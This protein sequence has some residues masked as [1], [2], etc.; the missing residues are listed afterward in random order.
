M[1]AY[2]DRANL[3]YLI[4]KFIFFCFFLLNN[5]GTWCSHIFFCKEIIINDLAFKIFAKFK[6]R[7][8]TVFSFLC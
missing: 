7:Y 1:N 5:H 6:S 4:F 3:F 8:V 2:N